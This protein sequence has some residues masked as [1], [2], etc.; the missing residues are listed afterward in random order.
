MSN[1]ATRIRA[2]AER[3]ATQDNRATS[4]PIFV[5]QTRARVYGFDPSYS[6]HHVWL[7]DGEVYEVDD[8]E[9]IARLDDAHDNGEE[10]EGFTRT[11]YQDRWEAESVFFTEDAA[12]AYIEANRHN[13]TEPRVYVASGYRNQEWQLVREFLLSQRE[14]KA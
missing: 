3:M 9:Q 13:L 8:P 5:V 14:A 1:I 7:S 10:P 12:N 4:H 11:A 6:D 2:M